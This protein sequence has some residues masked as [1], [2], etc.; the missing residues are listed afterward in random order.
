[1]LPI[2]DDKLLCNARHWSTAC[3]LSPRLLSLAVMMEL[4]MLW[5]YPFHANAATSL[6][7]PYECSDMP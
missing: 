4:E 7:Y 5:K 2:L 6:A 1:M 3:H